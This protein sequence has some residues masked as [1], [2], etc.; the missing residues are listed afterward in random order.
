MSDDQK[1]DCSVCHLET[2]LTASNE[3]E[4]DE[5]ECC[6][7][8]ALTCG[9]LSKNID[10]AVHISSCWSWERRCAVKWTAGSI[11][12]FQGIVNARRVACLLVGCMYYVIFVLL[13]VWN[14]FWGVGKRLFEWK[15]TKLYFVRLSC[16]GAW[17]I[18]DLFNWPQSRCGQR[19][20]I[21][22]MLGTC[23]LMYWKCSVHDFLKSMLFFRV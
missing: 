21:W 2:A 13:I 18:V 12:V 17:R 8:I 9:L 22:V 19:K 10:S 7:E 14:D 23:A 11:T 5:D 16:T 1:M 4:M 20:W 6:V 15:Q 3:Q